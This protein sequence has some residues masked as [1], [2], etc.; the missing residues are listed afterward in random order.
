MDD[1]TKHGGL[2][3]AY[4]K[5]QQQI[6]ELLRQAVEQATEKRNEESA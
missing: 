2:L 1:K 5:R 4:L 3:G 6:N